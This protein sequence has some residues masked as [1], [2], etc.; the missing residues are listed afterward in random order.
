MGKFRHTYIKALDLLINK[1]IEYMQ[2]ITQWLKT[3]LERN[4]RKYIICTKEKGEINVKSAGKYIQIVIYTDSSTT[5]R[6]KE[7]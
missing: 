7:I 1:K 6:E 3:Q 5:H 2:K 4:T